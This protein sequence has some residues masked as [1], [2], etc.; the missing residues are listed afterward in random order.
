M[1]EFVCKKCGLAHQRPPEEAG[2]FFRCQCGQDNRVPWG[3]VKSVGPVDLEPAE[4][5]GLVARVVDEG[6]VVEAAPVDAAPG[7]EVCFQH[8]QAAATRTCADCGVGFCEACLVKLQGETLCGPCKNL[9]LRRL[10]RPPRLSMPAVLST[11]F[12]LA[13]APVSLCV[14]G[15]ASESG[16]AGV[17]VF[18]AVLPLT[19]I[20]L[21]AVALPQIERDSRLAGRSL[22]ITGVVTG[23]V[24]VLLGAFITA[25]IAVN[26]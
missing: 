18:G 16:H 19:A 25:Y 15:A 9:R 22:A 21:G 5:A 6:E 4:E 26:K 12:A 8:E 10:Q 23:L 14:T 24:G 2:T 13:A 3:A 11:V 1:I 17:T 7:G 20:V